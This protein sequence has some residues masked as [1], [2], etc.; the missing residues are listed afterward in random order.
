MG[1][2]SLC[3]SGTS[4]ESKRWLSLD[5]CGIFG[6][7]LSWSVHLYA[8][9]V[10][11]LMLLSN[12]ML[13][14]VIYFAFY[15]PVAFLAMA[16]LF[17]AS[18][19]DP[20]AVPLG[21]RPLVTVR[22]ASSILSGDGTLE[23]DDVAAGGDDDV[24]PS[25]GSDSPTGT[26]QQQE[27]LQPLAP[28]P[29]PTSSTRQR[30]IRRCHKCQD[31]FKPPR[32]HHDSV[33]GRC[34]VKFDHF[35]PWVNNAVGALNHKFFCLFL[36]YTGIN[37]LL[38]LL[39]LFLR[40]VHCGYVRDEEEEATAASSV[41][42]KH[43]TGSSTHNVDNVPVTEDG[44]RGRLL[45]STYLYP[46]CND[47]YGSHWVMILFVVSLVFLIFTCSMGFEQL[48]AIET[49]KGKIA[50]MKMRVGQNGTEFQRVT[51]TYGVVTKKR[52]LFAGLRFVVT[53]HFASSDPLLN[54]T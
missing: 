2:S 26:R 17:M 31:N 43:E 51:G 20:G 39:L 11:P 50:R 49:G 45:S 47:F 46:E 33:T 23:G 7:L 38:S 9:S 25:S 52:L 3:G 30:A 6:I 13:S 5:P 22:R 36:L 10:I 15:L 35:C 1:R 4:F 8:I 44:Q 12:S 40:V 24:V 53:S 16:S 32:A 14:T 42:Q 19:S 29:P 54:S 28:P 34:I 27:P 37:C 18:T 41:G 21:A 48:E